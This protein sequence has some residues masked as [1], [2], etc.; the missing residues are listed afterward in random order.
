MTR[1]EL[2]IAWSFDRTLY[3]GEVPV[4]IQQLCS[5]WSKA[6]TAIVKSIRNPKGRQWRCSFDELSAT[7]T[8]TV[9]EGA[10]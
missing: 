5:Y 8:Q 10:A 3:Y 4:K 1:G 7:P 6:D 9:K 2:E